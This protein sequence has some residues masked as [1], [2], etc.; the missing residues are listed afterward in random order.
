[1]LFMQLGR[2]DCDGS[3]DMMF[4]FSA[5]VRWPDSDGQM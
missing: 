1:M 3:A 5:D 2:L 4:L